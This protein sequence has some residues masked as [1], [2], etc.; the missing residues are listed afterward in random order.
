VSQ[1]V[2]EENEGGHTLTQGGLVC[3]ILPAGYLGSS[4]WGCFFIVCGAA[5]S[6]SSYVA[7]GMLCL[8]L[9]GVLIFLAGN[10]VARCLC[11]FFLIILIAIFVAD[12]LLKFQMLQYILVFFGL[13]NALYSVFDI[14]DDLIKRKVKESDAYKFSENFGG[15]S[16][17]WGCLWWIISLCFLAA[18]VYF[19]LV[20]LEVNTTFAKPETG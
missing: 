5:S 18:A 2:V 15:D 3:C 4:F 13:M 17:C 1:L 11:L 6:I 12:V 19:S 7:A 9:L 16:R 10:G 8:A 20:A 14:M